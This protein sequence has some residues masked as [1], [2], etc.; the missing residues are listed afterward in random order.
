MNKCSKPSCKEKSKNVIE[1]KDDVYDPLLQGEMC[2]NSSNFHERIKIVLNKIYF[3]FKRNKV[4]Q[5]MFIE[6]YVDNDRST[7]STSINVVDPL[8]PVLANNTSFISELVSI[9]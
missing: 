5:K 2:C 8:H 1:F 9:S 7:V 6:S 4:Y 3:K